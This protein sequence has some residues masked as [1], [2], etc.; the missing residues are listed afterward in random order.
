MLAQLVTGF[1]SGLPLLLTGSTLQAWLKDSQVSLEAIGLFALVGLPYTLKFVWSPTF[2]RFVLPFLG[3]RRGWMLVLQL[4]LVLVIGLFGCLNPGAHPYA[5][6]LAAIIVTLFSASQDIV[7]DAYRREALSDSEIGLGAAIFVNGYRV[8]MLVSGALALFL[9]DTMSWQSVYFLMAGLM[10]VGILATLAITEPKV[11]APPPR[12]MR[13]AVALPFVDFFSRRGA[14][15]ALAFILLYKIGDQM[16]NSMT[17][18]F[19]LELGFS[20]TELAAVSKFFGL[21]AM[22]VGGFVGGLLMLRVGIIRALWLFGIAQAVTTLAYAVLAQTGR[23]MGVLAMATTVTSLAWG[24]G[25]VAQTAYMASLTNK[26]F[27]ATQFALLSSLMGVPRVIA[28]APTGYLA[29][30]L[31][32]IGFFVFC[33]VI[34]VPGLFLLGQLTARGPKFMEPAPPKPEV[35]SWAAEQAAAVE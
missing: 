2:D 24:M 32:W 6:A 35:T 25:S 1:S 15:L 33:T 12:S 18:P 27:S 3:R 5:V 7:L 29:H 17:T 19:V 31:G 30:Q 22:I 26:R 4:A 14:L 21:G 9:A 13:E 16:A 23:N 20:K 34:A 8:A 28:S 11:D 10:G